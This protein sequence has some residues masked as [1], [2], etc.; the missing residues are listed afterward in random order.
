[1]TTDDRRP[2]T[3]D[4]RPTTDGRR[5]TTDDRRPTTDDRRPTTDD[6]RPTTDD[7]AECRRR[8]V[9]R[10]LAPSSRIITAWIFRVFPLVLIRCASVRCASLWA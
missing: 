5:P 8:M 7:R 9:F 4:R 6:R 10:R 1:L 2:T 3:D